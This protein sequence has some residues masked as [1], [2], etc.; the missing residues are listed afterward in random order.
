MDKFGKVAS[1]KQRSIIC[2]FESD[3]GYQQNMTLN[4]LTVGAT[5]I[6]VQVENPRFKALGIRSGS[7]LQLLRKTYGCLHFRIGTAEFAIR[8]AD[9][10]M[11]KLL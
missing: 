3:Q 4:K 10:E 9:A 5:A 11:I 1:L 8:K 7:I 6:I 2:Q